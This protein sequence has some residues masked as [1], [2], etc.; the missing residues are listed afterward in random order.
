MIKIKNKNPAKKK[1]IYNSHRGTGSQIGATPFLQPEKYLVLG[2]RCPYTQ[3]GSTHRRHR[4]HNFPQEYVMYYV[5]YGRRSFIKF[6]FQLPK[7]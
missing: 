1:Y 6:D 4:L 7:V 3:H 5:L 2:G